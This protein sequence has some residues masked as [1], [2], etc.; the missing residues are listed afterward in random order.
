M[1]GKK[2]LTKLTELFKLDIIARLN[3]IMNHFNMS[4]F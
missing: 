4:K 2:N 1:F 3:T